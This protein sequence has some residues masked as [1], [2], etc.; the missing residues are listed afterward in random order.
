MEE[1]QILGVYDENYHSISTTIDAILEDFDNPPIGDVTFYY[2]TPIT[3][4]S[5]TTYTIK[6]K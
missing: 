4:S 3:V 2:L 1:K 6:P 5:E